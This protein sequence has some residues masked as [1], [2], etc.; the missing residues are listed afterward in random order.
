MH[1]FAH[2]DQ[3]YCATTCAVARVAMGLL[4]LTQ[5]PSKLPVGADCGTTG[6]GSLC[7]AMTTMVTYSRIPWHGRFIEAIVIPH[8]KLFALLTINLEWLAGTLLLLG[9]CTRA[10]ALLGLIQSL[11]LLVGLAWAPGEWFWPYAMMVVMHLVIL[12][13]ARH[14]FSLDAL[15]RRRQSVPASP[16][17][18]T[19]LA[20]SRSHRRP[21]LRR[22]TPGAHAA[23]RRTHV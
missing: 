22:I 3:W 17:A 21:E 12:G 19:L 20:A 7:T 15:L 10:G 16:P 9:L 1:P 4:W 14:D 13:Q 23:T 2:R 8:Y 6:D 18:P 5:L 11:N